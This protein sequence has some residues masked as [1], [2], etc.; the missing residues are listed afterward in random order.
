[1]VCLATWKVMC[2]SS[3]IFAAFV[4]SFRVR[5]EEALLPI[6]TRDSIELYFYKS[7]KGLPSNIQYRGI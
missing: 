2:L 6:L 4:I 3:G 7:S 1:M 5:L